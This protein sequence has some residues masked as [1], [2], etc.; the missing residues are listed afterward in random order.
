MLNTIRTFLT[1]LAQIKWNFFGIYQMD[2]N[3]ASL[4]FIFEE[5]N[6]EKPLGYAIKWHEE[7]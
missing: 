4:T 7:K 3:L 6:I 2:V 5:V 1:I